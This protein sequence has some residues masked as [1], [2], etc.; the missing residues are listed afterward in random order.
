MTIDE[1]RESGLLELY[2]IGDVSAA[3]RQKVEQMVKDH[4]ELMSEIQEI[5]AALGTFA[6]A[7][8]VLPDPSLKDTILKKISGSE[9]PKPP[10]NDKKSGNWGLGLLLASILALGA[11]LWGWMNK[12]QITEL[13]NQ[14]TILQRDCDSIV[15]AQ[16]NRL[17]FFD[18]LFNESD[19]LALSATP[20]YPNT[21]LF[22]YSNNNTQTNYLQAIN[23]PN[24]TPQQ[25]FQLWSLKGSG[26]PIPLST[27]SGEGGIPQE[28]DF[29][30]GTDVYAITIE[31]A[32]GSQAPNLDELIGT[33]PVG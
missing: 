32:G 14:L 1:L 17:A 19:V 27:F 5:E 9:K 7:H 26:A 21:T 3:E 2:V 20:K 24:I 6:L 22:L 10:S 28:I 4:P 13:E 30:G 23:L 29:E 11:L 25:V 33:I 18:G 16:G 12:S 8:A 15:D 31:P